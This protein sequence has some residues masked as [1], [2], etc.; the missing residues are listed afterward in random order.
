M[1][2]DH[3]PLLTLL[4]WNINGI[5]AAYRRGFLDWLHQ[6]SPDIL[7]LQETKADADQL[8]GDLRQPDGYHAFW[9]GSER[10][11]GYSGVA[12]LSR[13]EPLAVE[14]GLGRAEFDDEGRTII[15]HY[16]DFTL[17]NCYFPNG[18]RDHRRVPFKLAFYD[19]F[20]TLCERLRSEGRAV[21]F[22]GDVNT[23][24][25]EIDL[26]HP[27]PN[28]NATGFLPEE[29]AW[30]DHLT[31][32]GWVD[33]FRRFYP[34]LREQYT[35]WSLPTS[36][37]ERNVGWRIDYFFVDADNSARVANAFILPEVMGSDHCPVGIELR[38]G[39]WASNRFGGAPSSMRS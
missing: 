16:P 2:D 3:L 5:R 33:T 36:A 38:V 13:C 23:A 27:K 35:W 1:T 37:R 12:L 24:H 26:T 20:L 14:F 21:I 19:A 31:A 32:N 25:K 22:G 11:R 39:T 10:K 29:R 4:S 18:S 28:Q 34:D 6:T 7:C 8:P 30:L 15:A 9:H 17:I